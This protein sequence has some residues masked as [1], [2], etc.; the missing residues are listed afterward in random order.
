M[1]ELHFITHNIHKY[2]EAS[3]I[4]KDFKIPIKWL[5]V[6][7]EEIQDNELELIALTSCKNLLNKKPELRNKHF[8]AEDA[9]LFI[10]TLKGFPG[11][12][13]AYVFQTIGNEGILRLMENEENKEA[14]FKSVIA[15]YYNNKIELF[16]GETR[17]SILLEKH[18]KKGFGFDP[19][20]V[21]TGEEQSFAEMSLT[22]KNLYSHRQKSLREM[23]TSLT[24]FENKSI[25]GE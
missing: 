20:F 13:S 14:Y 19:I 6:E 23:F 4:A 21:P 11:P 3:E 5:N 10:N 2:E 12:F 7:Y 8:F 1:K 18:G 17:G 22:T 24:A 25:S 15:V 9:G 16:V